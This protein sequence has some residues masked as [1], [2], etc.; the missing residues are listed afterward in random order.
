MP[1]PRLMARIN[2]AVTNRLMDRTARSSAGFGVIHHVGRRTGRPYETPVRVLRDRGGRIVVPIAYGRASDWVRNVLHA[3]RF[4]MTRQGERI[5]VVDVAITDHPD[6]PD[7]ARRA[8]SGLRRIA[9]LDGY[10]VGRRL[11]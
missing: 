9:H 3:G 6:E 4:T 8:P 7:P 10:V 2:R 11:D 1:L 5:E